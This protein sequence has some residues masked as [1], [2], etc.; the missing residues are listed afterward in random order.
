MF[1]KAIKKGAGPILLSFITIGSIY[2][3]LVSEVSTLLYLLVTLPE[4]NSKFAPENG[5]LEY[6]RFLLGWPIFRG[7]CC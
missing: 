2:A 7:V 3:H 5:W 1:T 4:A 6:D